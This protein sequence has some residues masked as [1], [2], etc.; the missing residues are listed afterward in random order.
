[1]QRQRHIR[2]HACGQS[3]S[4]TF[5][6]RNYDYWWMDADGLRARHL[7]EVRDGLPVIET[8]SIDDIKAAVLRGAPLTAKLRPIDPN[9]EDEKS[10]TRLT[11]LDEPR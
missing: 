2:V 5:D 7:P 6:T 1:V 11:L 3:T 4:L 10:G 8:V 9:F